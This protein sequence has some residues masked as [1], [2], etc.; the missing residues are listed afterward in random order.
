MKL[1]A[2]QRRLIRKATRPPSGE[3]SPDNDELSIVPFLD[4]VINLVMVLLVMMASV[5]LVSQVSAQMPE[6]SPRP[7]PGEPAWR[8][9]VVLTATGIFVTDREGTFQAGCDAHGP[10]QATLPHVGGRPDLSGLRQCALT[11]H[12]AHP[13][14]TGFTITADPRVELA[15]LI[16]A[17][18]AMRGTP[19]QPLFTEPQIAAGVR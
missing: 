2:R 17:M 16:G 12:R 1:T 14:T 7:G 19:G 9:T 5:M 10:A 15:D 3:R 11:L 18:D 8:P 4:V 6:T 13:D